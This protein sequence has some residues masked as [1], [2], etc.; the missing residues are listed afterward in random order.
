MKMKFVLL[1]MLAVFAYGD[2]LSVVSQNPADDSFFC[3]VG[4]KIVSDQNLKS[5]V[6]FLK[7]HGAKEI[8]MRSEH[9]LSKAEALEVINGFKENRLSIKRYTI[10]IEITVHI[11]QPYRKSSSSKTVSVVINN[12]IIEKN[13]IKADEAYTA[14]KA[15]R[16]AIE[17]KAWLTSRSYQLLSRSALQSR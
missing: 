5:A 15:E 16:E 12:E 4:G 6:A 17:A 13:L 1:F 14:H 3:S 2:E 8:I 7:K 9:Y 11:D 10:P